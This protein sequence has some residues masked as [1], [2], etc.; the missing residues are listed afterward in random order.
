MP[1]YSFLPTNKYVFIGF[2]LILLG[3]FTLPIL[4]GLIIMPIGIGLFL[5]GLH[6]AYYEG[7]KKIYS[8]YLRFK[9]KN[10]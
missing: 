6:K 9:S 4:I 1:W 7:G 2:V 10:K 8:Y 5:F 3:F